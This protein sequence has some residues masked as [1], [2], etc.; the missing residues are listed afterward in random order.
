MSVECFCFAYGAPY[1]FHPCE[2]YAYPERYMVQSQTGH[3]LK[4]VTKMLIQPKWSA[5]FQEM[6]VLH[7]LEEDIKNCFISALCHLI[8]VNFYNGPYP[9]FDS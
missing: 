4:S 7:L 9:P 5:T 3:L 1:S 8:N 2:R 6:Q